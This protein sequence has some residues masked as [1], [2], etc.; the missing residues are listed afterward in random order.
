MEEQQAGK[1]SFRFVVIDEAFLKSSDES[2]RYGLQLFK[3]LDLQLMIVTPLLKI[4]II[5]Q[6]IAHV[7]FVHHNDVRHESMLRNISIDEYEREREEREAVRSVQM[8]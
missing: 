5:A 1:R 8:V 7:G 4:P 3:N 6:F 2:A